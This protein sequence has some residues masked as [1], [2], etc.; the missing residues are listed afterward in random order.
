MRLLITRPQEDGE[1]LAALLRAQGHDVV[2]APLMAIRSVA[3]VSL[4]LTDVRALLITSRNGA[5]ALAAAT[6]RRDVPVLAVG[7]SSAEAA[8]ESGFT[9]VR[10][11]GGD[12]EALARLVLRSVRPEEGLL[13]HVAGSAV[14]GDLAG[15]LPG[16][17][18][19]RAVL[20]E[21]VP[22]GRLPEPA[23]QFLLAGQ[24]GGILLYSPRS[25]ALFATLAEA[26]AFTAPFGALT[27]FCLSEAVAEAA[28]RLP[29][30]GIAVAPRPEQ[31]ALLAL[32]PLEPGRDPS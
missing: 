29:F 6:A 9:E 30:G 23:R 7:A 8:R 24:P 27:G 4:D 31:A 21:A 10:S 12:V 1:S 25:A 19:R 22:C 16:Y 14:A 32:I 11:A 18:V 5:R 2:L 17:R 20:Y 28:R 26:E 15:L 13:L 3:G